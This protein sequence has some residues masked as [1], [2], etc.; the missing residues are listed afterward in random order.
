MQHPGERFRGQLTVPPADVRVCH[1]RLAFVRRNVAARNSDAANLVAE[2]VGVAPESLDIRA[3]NAHVGQS[4]DIHAVGH[5]S[6]AQAFVHF[7]NFL[8]VRLR[9][10]PVRLVELHAL[11]VVVLRRAPVCLRSKQRGGRHDRRRH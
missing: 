6:H 9:V 7:E 11:L 2:I 8:V 1:L 4:H 5:V 3:H 10:F